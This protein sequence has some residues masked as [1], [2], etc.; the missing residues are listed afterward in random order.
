MV[1]AYAASAPQSPTTRLDD[2]LHTAIR[3]FVDRDASLRGDGTSLYGTLLSRAFHPD[4]SHQYHPLATVHA[5]FP[6]WTRADLYAYASVV[7][8]EAC[9]GPK[10]P[11]RKGRLDEETTDSTPLPEP[12]ST[13]ANLHYLRSHGWSDQEIVVL[14]GAHT[15][16]RADLPWTP[17]ECVCNN[18]YF[19]LLLETQ[20]ARKVSHNGR[21]WKGPMLYEDPTGQYTMSPMDMALLEDPSLRSWVQVYAKNE[22]RFRKDLGKAI[23]KLLEKDLPEAPPKPWYKVW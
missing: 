2:N 13:H 22:K 21:A 8:L 20:W 17:H 4:H 19:K 14:M 18:E 6:D 7:A 15:L 11:F 9:G 16:G 12:S 5:K 23:E 10:V 3:D 1:A